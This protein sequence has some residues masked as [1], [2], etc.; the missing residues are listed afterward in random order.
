LKRDTIRDLRDISRQRGRTFFALESSA[1]A[2]D[3]MS[4]ATPGKPP[5][6]KFS[7]NPPLN[8]PT[9]PKTT[10][11]G[12]CAA[13]DAS[14]TVCNIPTK[15]GMLWCPRHNEERVKLYVNYKKHHT[16]LDA[17]PEDDVCCDD[18]EVMTCSSLDVLSDWNTALMTR[19]QLLT[20]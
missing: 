1:V 19:Y 14:G 9:K 2:L 16:A 13:L 8:S 10:S 11:P 18:D 3:T 6:R 4:P 20:R 17:L 5:K 15:P 7:M 12:K